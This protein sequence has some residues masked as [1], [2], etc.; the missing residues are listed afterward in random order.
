MILNPV[1]WEA[2]FAPQTPLQSNPKTLE[3]N[4]LTDS[5]GGGEKKPL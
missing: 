1:G 4:F 5:T 3:V 2:N